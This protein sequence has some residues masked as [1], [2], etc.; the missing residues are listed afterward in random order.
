MN[1]VLFNQTSMYKNNNLFPHRYSSGS[2]MTR[3]FFYD[4]DYEIMFLNMR[5][6]RRVRH[7]AVYCKTRTFSKEPYCLLMRLKYCFKNKHDFFLFVH[8][9]IVFQPWTGK[10]YRFCGTKRG[11]NLTFNVT[12]VSVMNG[13]D[14]ISKYLEVKNF[15]AFEHWKFAPTWKYFFKI[16]ETHH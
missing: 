1:G 8:Q 9:L 6:C 12:H 15:Y 11:L 14:T 16:S 3:R 7:R 4:N 10:F 2:P 13:T 5:F